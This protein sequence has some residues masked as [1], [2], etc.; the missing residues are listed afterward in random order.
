M[1]SIDR[2]TEYATK[3]GVE[4]KVFDNEGSQ[5]YVSKDVIESWLC[6][7][8]K[9]KREFMFDRLDH[10]II[11]GYPDEYVKVEK[12]VE[13]IQLLRSHPT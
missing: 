4:I 2:F 13:I 12:A 3:C 9:K 11:H 7:N 8:L 10:H 5:Q 6:V 1:S